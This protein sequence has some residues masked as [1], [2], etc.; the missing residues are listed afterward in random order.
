MADNKTDIMPAADFQ[1]LPLEFIVAAPLVAAVKAQAM[2]AETTKNFISAMIEKGK[3]ITV[4]F[5]VSYRDEN[6]PGKKQ[7]KSV[8]ISAP[9]L[10]LVPVPH[11]RIDSITTHFK[12]EVT[13]TVRNASATEKGVEAG[14][15]SGA[16]LSPWVSG[17]IKGS[18]SSKS[19]EESTMNRSGTLEI[20][21]HASEAPIPEGLAKILSFLGT[22]MQSGLPEVAEK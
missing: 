20:T 6:A 15:Q 18:L 13:Q 3:P 7:D 8:T 1:A 2:V 11:L 12:Y 21:V 14:F 19:S 4:D 16:L 10:S 22:A 9:L 17:T 5:S